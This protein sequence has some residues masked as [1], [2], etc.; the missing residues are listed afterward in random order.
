MEIFNK[1]KYKL[2]ENIQGLGNSNLVEIIPDYNN[3]ESEKVFSGKNNTYIV[4]GRDRP[5]DEFSGYG[6]VGESNCGS[7]DIVSGR[8]SAIDKKELYQ[9]SLKVN[10]DY[11]LDAARIII[12]Q[13]TNIDQNFGLSNGK[14]GN[15]SGRSAVGIKA[16]DVRI[17]ARNGIKLV[18]N[19]D[20]YDSTGQEQI[21]QNGIDI[22]AN[23]DDENLQPMV[24]GDNLSEYLEKLSTDISKVY[25]ELTA[26]HTL[27]VSLMSALSTHTHISSPVGGPTTPSIEL[28]IAIASVSTELSMRIIDTSTAAVKSSAD[29]IEYLHSFSKKYIKS[30]FNNNN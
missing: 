7:I 1:N 4:M 19:T 17:I 5:H 3:A 13:K 8:V 30:R 16:D 9:K 21:V 22:I 23:N 24:L 27:L 15:S 11:F 20:R 25:T 18:T 29:K 28:G 2:D 12:S 6:G 10:N 26:I 14:V